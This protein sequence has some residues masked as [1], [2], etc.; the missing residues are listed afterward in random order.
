MAKTLEQQLTC[1]QERARKAS[2]TLICIG[3]GSHGFRAEASSERDRSTT[4]EITRDP[5]T[6]DLVCTCPATVVCKHIGSALLAGAS[7]HTNAMPS[8]ALPVTPNLNRPD[9]EPEPPAP[10][11]APKLISREEAIA[12][13]PLLM[14]IEAEVA[15]IEAEMEQQGFCWSD[16]AR[17]WVRK[18][19]MAQRAAAALL[20][21][22][23]P[24]T[25]SIF[26][27]VAQ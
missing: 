10:S 2:I 11:A 13:F 21:D 26:K 18:P 22:P 8:S 20:A 24:E 16:E 15:R 14:D 12:D 5:Q 23:T 27:G 7:Y 1:A 9:P 3:A 6:H 17:T 25:F 19:P 4:Y